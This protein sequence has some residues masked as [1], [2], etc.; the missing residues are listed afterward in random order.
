MLIDAVLRYAV[1]LPH[2]AIPLR[3][4]RALQLEIISYLPISKS[5]YAQL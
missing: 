4:D 2:F 1:A 5:P 3:Q